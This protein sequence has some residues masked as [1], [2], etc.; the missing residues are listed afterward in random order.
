MCLTTHHH[1]RVCVGVGACARVRVR[2]CSRVL[3][4]KWCRQMVF[5]ILEMKKCKA[6]ADLT[7]G[8][9]AARYASPRKRTL[10]IAILTLCVCRMLAYSKKQEKRVDVYREAVA[11]I[12]GNCNFDP[13]QV[14]SKQIEVGTFI[15]A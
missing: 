13:W 8:E 1:H 6:R 2:V 3:T 5:S 14:N 4:R 15:I 7:P 11:A 10:S 12:F 9:L